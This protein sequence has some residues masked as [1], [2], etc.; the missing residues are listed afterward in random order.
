LPAGFQTGR[1]VFTSFIPST[2]GRT[3]IPLKRKWSIPESAGRKFD[4]LKDTTD[5]GRRK[6][7]RSLECGSLLPPFFAILGT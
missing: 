5:Q 6:H 2:F 4:S 1:A 3:K 7:R